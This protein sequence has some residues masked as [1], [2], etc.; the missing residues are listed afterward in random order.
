VKGSACREAVA[1]S[2]KF[3]LIRNDETAAVIW[4][5]RDSVLGASKRRSASETHFKSNLGNLLAMLY[6]CEIR[7]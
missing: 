5:V 1:K 3:L 6:G 4:I 7:S 2:H